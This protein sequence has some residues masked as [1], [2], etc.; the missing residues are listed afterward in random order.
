SAT[1]VSMMGGKLWVESSLGVGTTFH[2][3]LSCDIAAAPMSTPRPGDSDDVRALVIDD[4]E[5][6]RRL[7]G[8]QLTRWRMLPTAVEGGKRAL[9][10]LV[11]AANQN[12]PYRLVLLD[13]NMPE[14]DGFEVAEEIQKRAELA[15]ATVM[16]LTSS[17]QY[18]D[19]GRCRE[20]GVSAYL[21]KPIKAADLRDAIS[22]ALGLRAHTEAAEPAEPIAAPEVGRARVL[23]VEDNVVNQKVAMGLL[24]RRGHAVIVAPDGQQALDILDRQTFDVVLMDLQMPVMGGLE[25]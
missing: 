11:R 21:T 9:E 24:A 17:G 25:A 2:F 23:L 8:G 20:L 18:G 6:N 15:G 12:S 3:T 13:A 10:E 4:N 16:M 19:Q 22:R 1:L 7:L 5:I 14:M